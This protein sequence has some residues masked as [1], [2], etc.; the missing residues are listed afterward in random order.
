M[1]RG[2]VTR[3]IKTLDEHSMLPHAQ[4]HP[5][6]F[7]RAAKE[8]AYTCPNAKTPSRQPRGDKTHFNSSKLRGFATGRRG[9]A[10]AFL[11]RAMWT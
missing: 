9:M 7:S 3:E 5:N 4:A 2:S 11:S 6:A 8:F 10:S 1:L